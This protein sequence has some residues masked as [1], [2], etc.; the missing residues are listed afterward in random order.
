MG[1]SVASVSPSPSESIS[2]MF[3]GGQVIAQVWPCPVSFRTADCLVP[4]CANPESPRFFSQV[5]YG[6][7][8]LHS[9]SRARAVSRSGLDPSPPGPPLAVPQGMSCP[10]PAAHPG[11]EDATAAA[12]LSLA[13]NSCSLQS[14]VMH[15]G[16]EEAIRK[17][18]YQHPPQKK[19]SQIRAG[20]KKKKSNSGPGFGR[21][22]RKDLCCG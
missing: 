9:I 22:D 19:T 12:Y 13:A 10:L 6:Q 1:A 7:P 3:D 5:P 15:Q 14:E 4:P 21:I 18:Y 11:S 20:W 17:L 2:I 16:G 8:S